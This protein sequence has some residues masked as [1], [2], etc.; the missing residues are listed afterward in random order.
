MMFAPAPDSTLL[1]LDTDDQSIFRF[2]PLSLQ[3]QKQLQPPAGRMDPLPS[4]PASAMTVSP[5]H[6]L[7][8]ALKDEV[9][10]ATDAP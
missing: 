8:L 7:F 4:V 5:N 2:T 9:Y 6:I 1:I 10:F 3:L